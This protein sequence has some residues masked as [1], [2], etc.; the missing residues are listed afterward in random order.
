MLSASTTTAAATSSG[1]AER[2]ARPSR[3]GVRAAERTLVRIGRAL[4]T[5]IRSLSGPALLIWVA[6]EAR[7]ANPLDARIADSVRVANALV[8]AAEVID[9]N[10]LLA[11]LLRLRGRACGLPGIGQQSGAQ[12]QQYPPVHRSLL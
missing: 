11:A 3:H 4:H 10:S 9:D 6:D 7:V 2:C 1:A 12:C 5:G 8:L